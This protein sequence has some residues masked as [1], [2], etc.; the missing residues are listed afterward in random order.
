MYQ[1][2]KGLFVA[3]LCRAYQLSDFFLPG[4]KSLRSIDSLQMRRASAF[5]VFRQLFPTLKAMQAGDKELCIGK[6]DF[7]AG[8]L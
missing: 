8:I 3:R 2:R 7:I 5:D 6:T 1:F 4:Q